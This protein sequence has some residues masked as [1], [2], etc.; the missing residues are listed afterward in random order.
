MGRGP[1]GKEV[2]STGPGSEK[3]TRAGGGVATGDVSAAR[4]DP[5]L[6]PRGDA[7]SRQP[8]PPP[9][10]PARAPG[11]Q[12]DVAGLERKRSQARERMRRFR[13]RQREKR[14]LA[15]NPDDSPGP[16]APIPPPVPDSDPNRSS[17]VVGGLDGARPRK[18]INW[19]EPDLWGPIQAALDGRGSVRSALRSL[20]SGH[21]DG[22]YD[23]LSESTARGWFDVD[24]AGGRTL[25][26]SVRR[27]VEAERTWAKTPRS[28]ALAPSAG[29][30]FAS[31]AALFA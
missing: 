12:P 26:E 31:A 21:P 17:Q 28:N 9:S 4:A 30:A 11:R 16:S 7:A 6:D 2:M 14:A 25:K 23:R 3:M 15:D 18:Y 27:R 19:L 20:Q 22:R 10:P 13:K 29:G 24:D 1:A 5:S 8:P